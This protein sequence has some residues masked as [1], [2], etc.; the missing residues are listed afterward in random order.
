MCVLLLFIFLAII[1][2]RVKS[3][4][5]IHSL[6]LILHLYIY[7]YIYAKCLPFIKNCLDKERDEKKKRDRK[8]KE[9]ADC[10]KLTIRQTDE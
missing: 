2:K 10:Q 1:Q 3:I 6:S 9:T 5:I 8:K 4:T 7:I